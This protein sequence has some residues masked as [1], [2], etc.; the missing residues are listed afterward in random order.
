MEDT[1]R[2]T[3]RLRPFM[4]AD[5]RRGFRELFVTL[6]LASGFWLAA[7]TLV[8]NGLWWLALPL[9]PLAALM[10]VRLFIIQHDCGHGALFSTPALNDR[11]GR[12]L[13]IIT[14]TP[15]AYWRH[16]HNLHHAGSGNLDKRGVG[17][18]IKTLTVA[19]YEALD[20]WGRLSYRAYRHPLVLF[21]I[22]PAYVFLIQQRWPYGFEDR[23]EAWISSFA[24]NA[25]ILAFNGALLYLFGWQVMLIVHLPAVLMGSIMG[26]WLF[27]IQHQFDPTFWARAPEWQ[28]EEAAL[29]GSS[30]YDLPKPL[31]WATG[32]IGIHHVHHL[33]AR[34][35]FWR[36]PEVLKAYP[37]F[38]EKGRLTFWQSLKCVRLTL[39]DEAAK[40]LIT[41]RDFSRM[42]PA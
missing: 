20:F 36:L 1:K 40:R 10:L 21:A 8:Q 26:V 33:A 37:E 35:P 27:Y 15:Y 29:E 30:F 25:G 42:Q 2:W 31:M 41:F 23:R 22:G 13:G 24:T 11:V 39:W 19:E 18:D 34:V 4:Q 6:A 17:G 5:D 38:G 14:F 16:S 3:A 9:L 32:N 28:R 7:A 12:V